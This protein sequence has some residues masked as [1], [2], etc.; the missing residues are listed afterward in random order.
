MKK[1]LIVTIFVTL[2]LSGFT[3]ARKLAKPPQ[4]VQSIKSTGVLVE[5]LKGTNPVHR[6]GAFVSLYKLSSCDQKLK[7]MYELGAFEAL[8]LFK[9]SNLNSYFVFMVH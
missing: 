9:Q 1:K 3:E 4:K 2:F 6:M 5:E 7:L 8:E